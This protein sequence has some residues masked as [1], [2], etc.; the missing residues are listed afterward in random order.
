[1]QFT[2]CYRVINVNLTDKA[3]VL[4][5]DIFI[6]KSLHTTTN[7]MVLIPLKKKHFTEKYL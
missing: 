5:F 7:A 2:N 6:V 3:N 1:M 4:L